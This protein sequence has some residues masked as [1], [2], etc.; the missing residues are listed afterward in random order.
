MSD[1]AVLHSLLPFK[2]SEI[3]SINISHLLLKNK[4]FLDQ[5][6]KKKD[7]HIKQE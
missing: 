2:Q 1:K 4:L 7:K 5:M 6:L 3:S